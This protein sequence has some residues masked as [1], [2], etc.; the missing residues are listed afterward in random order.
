[1]TVKSQ[2]PHSLIAMKGHPATGKSSLAQALARTLGWPLLDKDDVKDHT[3]SLPDGNRLAYTILWQ[4]LERQLALGLSVIVDS[5]LSY[6]RD[7]ATVC[8]LAKRYDVRLLVVETQLEEATWRAR[9]E[10][11]PAH[12]ST[13]KIR[14]W[15][16]MQAQLQLYNDCWRYPIQPEYHL[17]VD[18]SRPLTENIHL[19][20]QSI[21]NDFAI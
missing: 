19:I 17:P 16:A 20:K 2:S 13:H 5:P 6:P 18:S 12:E 1:M 4:L 10:A 15:Q 21:L 11:R 7:Y 9:L 8:A 14:G 3:L